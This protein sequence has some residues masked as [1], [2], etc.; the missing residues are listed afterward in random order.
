MS[1]T[2]KK[3]ITELE[4]IDNKFLEVEMMSPSYSPY[5]IDRIIKSENNKKVYLISPNY[6]KEY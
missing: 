6:T 3:L 5:P 4:K 2:V 1:I